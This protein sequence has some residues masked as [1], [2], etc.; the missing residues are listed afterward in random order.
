MGSTITKIVA[1]TSPLAPLQ[2]SI[3]QL[4]DQIN[5]IVESHQG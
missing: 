5:Q 4:T 2:I 3:D 1:V